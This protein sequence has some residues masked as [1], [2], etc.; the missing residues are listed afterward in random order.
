MEFWIYDLGNLFQSVNIFPEKKMSKEEKLNSLTRLTIIISLLIM[1]RRPFLGFSIFLIIIILIIAIGISSDCV[2]TFQENF[3]KKMPIYKKQLSNFFDSRSH[4]AARSAAHE[5]EKVEF[6]LQAGAASP[7]H[8]SPIPDCNLSSCDDDLI[9]L[10]KQISNNQKLA[11]YARGKINIPPY[12]APP[13]FS[14]SWKNNAFAEKS[15]INTERNFDPVSSGYYDD[16]WCGECDSVPACERSSSTE[17]VPSGHPHRSCAA[18]SAALCDAT[19]PQFIFEKKMPERKTKLP[20]ISNLG[21]SEVLNWKEEASEKSVSCE[22]YKKLPVAYDTIY[23][24][25][26]TGYASNNRMYLDD[27]NQQPKFDY[28][29]IERI[30]MPGIYRNNID[31]YPYASRKNA[32]KIYLENTLNYR[33]ELQ[34]LYM[35][36]RNS[37][38]W[39][40]KEAPLRTSRQVGTALTRI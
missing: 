37:E 5:G 15:Q 7:H 39:Q 30:T 9:P 17:G 38:M 32:D 1:F 24:P 27:L 33:R 40:L 10:E 3:S 28:S 12:I 19:I 23:D 34:D 11:G 22:P 8:G 4:S 6:A 29:D 2:E 31:F 35:R 16:A 21:I 26:F 20:V 18:R 25:R 36:K 13:S 14:D